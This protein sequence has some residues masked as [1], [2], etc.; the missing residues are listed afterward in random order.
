M[1]RWTILLQ[2]GFVLLGFGISQVGDAFGQTTRTMVCDAIASS[3][4]SAGVAAKNAAEFGARQ[5]AAGKTQFL[6]SG[7]VMCAW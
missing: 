7:Q 4:A 3:N 5:L 6:L 2:V 1:K